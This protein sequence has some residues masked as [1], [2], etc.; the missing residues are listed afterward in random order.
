[1]G[2]WSNSTIPPPANFCFPLGWPMLVPLDAAGH[3]AGCC[4]SPTSVHCTRVYG[5]QCSMVPQ[6]S[7]S[8]QEGWSIPPSKGRSWNIAAAV[9]SVTLSYGSF[10]RAS[11]CNHLCDSRM[12]T[13][14]TQKQPSFLETSVQVCPSIKLC[15]NLLWEKKRGKNPLV[16]TQLRKEHGSR[17]QGLS[18]ERN[19]IPWALAPALPLQKFTVYIGG[20]GGKRG[21][22]RAIT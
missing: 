21:S 4:W 15:L 18:R 8:W 2:F 20:F 11:I 1:M 14:R 19:C 6:R 17:K 22:A 13:A 9:P 7:A 10:P 16:C 5:S 12:Q 3:E